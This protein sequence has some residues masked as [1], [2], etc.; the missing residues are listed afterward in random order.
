M[1]VIDNY[2]LISNWESI[3]QWLKREKSFRLFLSRI[4][5]EE[6]KINEISERERKIEREGRGRGTVV[7]E[8]CPHVVSMTFSNAM[9]V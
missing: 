9:N 5:E 3:H 8:P 4:Q 6:K 1:N 7:P 2:Q